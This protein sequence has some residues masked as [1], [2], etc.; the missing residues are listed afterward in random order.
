MKIIFSRKGFDSGYGGVP[1]PVFPDGQMVTLPIPGG[2]APHRFSEVATP[3]GSMG[4]LAAQLTKRPAFRHA[5][6]HLDPDLDATSIPRRPGWRASLG[7]GGAAQSHLAGQGVGPGDIFLFFGWFREVEAL[8]AGWAYRRGAPAIHALFGYLQIGEVLHVGAHPDREALLAE[9]PWLHDHPHTDT[10]HE[11]SVNNTIYLA[12]DR[13]VLPSGPTDLPGA[14]AF[15]RLN[16]AQVLTAPGQAKSKWCLPGWCGPIVAGERAGLSYHGDPA[17]W[18]AQPD[19]TTWL[20]SVAKG[21]EFV[22]NLPGDDLAEAWLRT[23]VTAP[24]RGAVP[25]PQA[26]FGPEAPRRRARRHP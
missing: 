11:R 12:S 18:S 24:L 13:L 8:G 19:G 2:M 17:R 5:A 15:D 23:C 1:S 14:G 7:Q 20:N 21:Q 22:M 3:V 10:A 25:V 16:P 4:D 26:G 9:R 6:V